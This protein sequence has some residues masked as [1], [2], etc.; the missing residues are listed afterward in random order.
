MPLVL[1]ADDEPVQRV[2]IRETLSADPTFTFIEAE[3]G[4]Q[5]LAQAQIHQPDLII[6]DIMM[7]E[8]SGLQVCQRLRTDPTRQSTP[9]L[10]ISASRT[11]D[12][13][14]STH[15]AGADRLLKKPFSTDEL[16][17]TVRSVLKGMSEE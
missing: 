8:L 3:N 7:P 17:I 12:D 16:L 5:A 11:E 14:A 4:R 2:L 9:I 10:L 15:A 6:L 13:E 1:I